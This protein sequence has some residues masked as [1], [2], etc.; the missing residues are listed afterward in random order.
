MSQSSGTQELE[1]SVLDWDNPRSVINLVPHEIQ[2]Y[3]AKIPGELLLL[4]ESQLRQRSKAQYSTNSG[5]LNE[6]DHRLRISFWVEYNA[7]QANRRNMRMNNVY[8]GVCSRQLFYAE[9]LPKVERLA[10]ILCAPTDYLKGLMELQNLG[11]SELR[12]ILETP[13]VRKNSKGQEVMSGSVMTAKIEIMKMID[14]R[15]NGAVIQKQMHVHAHGKIATPPQGAR[16]PADMAE[17]DA[18][19][20]ELEGL[21]KSLP[22]TELKLSEQVSE[23]EIVSTTE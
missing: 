5:R 21:A 13:I 10:W 16:P 4:D 17:L 12:K 11:L 6:T 9:V 20:A 15:L 19:L 7:A 1:S 18:R 14:Q 22:S 8:G 2:N 3:I 23:A